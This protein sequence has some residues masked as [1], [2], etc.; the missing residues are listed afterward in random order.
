MIYIAKG[1]LLFLACLA[2]AWSVSWAACGFRSSWGFWRQ[3]QA[4]K[5]RS[6][7]QT[8]LEYRN[9]L[10]LQC[11]RK[12]CSLCFPFSLPLMAF[13]RSLCGHH[14][15][16]FIKLNQVKTLPWLKRL[17]ARH[18]LVPVQCRAPPWSACQELCGW[19]KPRSARVLPGAD[20]MT[21]VWGR[22]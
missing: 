10:N 20:L 11:F 17:P 21:S 6:P 4:R 3:T 7:C 2:V 1:V 9:M 22:A 5:I 14:W 16:L 15:R 12:K 18:Q 19:L 13:I 8:R